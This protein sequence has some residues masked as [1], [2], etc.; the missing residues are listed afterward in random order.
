MTRIFTSPTKVVAL[1]V[2]N[3]HDANKQTTDRWGKIL[4]NFPIIGRVQRMIACNYG[5]KMEGTFKTKKVETGEKTRLGKLSVKSTG[6]RH[7][8][9]WWNECENGEGKEVEINGNRIDKRKMGKIS[10]RLTISIVSAVALKDI[11]K[12]F[13]PRRSWWMLLSCEIFE[14]RQLLTNSR[15][16]TPHTSS[17]AVIAWKL[18]LCRSLSCRV[19]SFPCRRCHRYEII[20]INVAK[21]DTFF[22]GAGFDAVV[23]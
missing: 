21:W 4:I 22:H 7:N 19:F 11:E 6:T 5:T 1:Y 18:S 10:P 16:N 15:A 8:E 23:A 2:W 14:M 9:I 20:K 12:S 3:E 17:R 13:M